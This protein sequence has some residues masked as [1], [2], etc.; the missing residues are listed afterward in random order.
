MKTLFSTGCE[1]R[2]RG[3]R[4]AFEK[5]TSIVRRSKTKHPDVLTIQYHIYDCFYSGDG[6]IQKNKIGYTDRYTALADAF[7]K[8]KYQNVVLVETHEVHTIDE[9]EKWHTH[10][11][12]LQAPYEGVMIRGMNS[13]YKQQGRSKDL[14]KYKKFHD[15]EFVR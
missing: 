7:G 1:L 2:A 15:D 12:T 11:T 13:P 3:S 5:I 4:V 6:N 9:V 8:N 10:F 14:L